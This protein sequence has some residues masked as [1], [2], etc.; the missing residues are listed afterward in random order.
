MITLDRFTTIRPFNKED[1]CQK[2]IFLSDKELL[3]FE[4]EENNPFSQC[5]VC[6]GYDYNCSSYQENSFGS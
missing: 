1:I 5:A 2:K 6:D 3:E 4:K